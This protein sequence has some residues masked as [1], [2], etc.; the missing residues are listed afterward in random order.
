VPATFAGMIMCYNPRMPKK[1]TPKATKPRSGR[2]GDPVSLYP[3]T[4]E[5]AVRG[6]FQIKP[7]DVKRI[8]ASKPGRGKR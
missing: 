7:E 2:R 4:A 6:M 1:P 3:L 5:Q 8:L